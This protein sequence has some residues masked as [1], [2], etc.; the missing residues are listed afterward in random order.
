M[1]PDP[2]L[3]IYVVCD[4]ELEGKGKG[5]LDVDQNF[6]LDMIA[7]TTNNTQTQ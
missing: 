2:N 6:A 1:N 3:T 7:L 5:N 4:L